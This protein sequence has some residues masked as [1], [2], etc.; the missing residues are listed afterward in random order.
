M[1]LKNDFKG[2]TGERIPHDWLNTIANFWNDL[3]VVGGSLTRRSDGRF[4]TIGFAGG[5]GGSPFRSSFVIVSSS[6]TIGTLLPGQFFVDGVAVTIT[7]LPATVAASAHREAW[8]ERNTSS[9]A[10]DWKEGTAT[11]A[12]AGTIRV[13]PVLEIDV[14]GG[15]IATVTHAHPADFHIGAGLTATGTWQLMGTSAEHG[16]SAAID[17]WTSGGTSGLQF[18]ALVDIGYDH[19]AGTPR[20]YGVKRTGTY[21][22]HGNLTGVSAES[23]VEIDVP[24]SHALLGT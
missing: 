13:Y 24:I 15:T 20:L 1:R 9:S 16:D 2:Q 14:A 23:L 8:I 21:D 12:S 19:T 18:T 3:Q 7:G 22:R 4:T 11:P 6:G 10:V 5:G 17:T